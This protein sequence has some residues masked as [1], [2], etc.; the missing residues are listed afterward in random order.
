MKLVS[1]L[2]FLNHLMI[3]DSGCFYFY[4]FTQAIENTELIA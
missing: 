3:N 1:A 4:E 2:N